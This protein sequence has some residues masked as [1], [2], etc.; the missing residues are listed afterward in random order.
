MENEPVGTATPGRN[1]RGCG[2]ISTRGEPALTTAPGRRSAGPC[3]VN[4]AEEDLVAELILG[5]MLRHVTATTA[6][7]WV[8]TDEPCVVEVLGHRATTFCVEGHH[9]ALVVVEDLRPASVIPYEVLLD[10]EVRW[11]LPDSRFP[12]SVVRT[13]GGAHPSRVLFGSCRFAAP[14]DPPWSLEPAAGG[15]SVG[16]DAMR[17]YALAMLQEPA[18]SWP[19]LVVLLGDQVYADNPSPGTL[20][21]VRARRRDPG[22]GA[23]ADQVADFE[24]YCWLYQEAWSPEVERW[25]FSVVPSAMIFDDHD[26]V[27]DWNIS[28]AWVAD[29][30]RLPWWEARVTGALVSY[31]LY[32]HLGNLGPAEIRDE[33]LLEKLH[34]VPDG[35]PML[36]EWARR[37]EEF[38]PVPGGYR[39]SYA[40]DLGPVRLVVA[41]ARNGRV[42]TPGK[43]L[44]LDAEEFAFVS[45]HCRA[46]ADHLLVATSLP[47]F[48]PGGLSDVQSWNEAVCDGAWGTWAARAGEWLRRALDL[49]DWPAFSRSFDALT[50]L[51]TSV[52]QGVDGPAPAT[53]AILS[54]D[55][56][57]SYVSEVDLSARGPSA[58]RLH[59]IVSSP[60]RNALLPRERRAIRAGL[61]RGGSLLGRA[62][63]R[64]AGRRRSDLRWP[65]TH[66]PL[67]GNNIGEM[68]FDGNRAHLRLLHAASDGEGRPHL[69]AV[70][71]VDL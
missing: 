31:W 17:A 55:I 59:Q 37:S 22:A 71:E 64:A 40:R 34:G 8:E 1:G 65:L 68:T 56:H 69:A 42:L 67:F 21:R 38:T 2:K 15:E 66:G 26:F 39:F 23:P 49:E 62:L 30:R 46:P 63:R 58:T 57:F 50:D 33:G 44:M 6:T 11:P 51:L 47:V 52:S 54:G 61:S 5:P 53:I 18:E 3:R 12:P 35:G 4:G 41:D 36:R 13:L 32:Q 45:A 29:I 7:V 19:Q 20:R 27:D 48:V 70:V 43:R 10:G 24:E 25:F 16:V 60:I 9:Y 28:A 14:H